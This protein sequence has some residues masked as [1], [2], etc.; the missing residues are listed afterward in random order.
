VDDRRLRL[1]VAVFWHN[2]CCRGCEPGVCGEC[3]DTIPVQWTGSVEF[4]AQCACD[5]CYSYSCY[6]SVLAET[7][8]GPIDFNLRGKP[9]EF[10][11]NC[12]WTDTK[13]FEFQPSYCE[14]C[15]PD[16]CEC[17]WNP[18]GHPSV[19]LCVRLT[20][21]CAGGFWTA[22]IGFSWSFNSPD[23]SGFP[24]WGWGFTVAG[25]CNECPPIDCNDEWSP[26]SFSNT[27]YVLGP[28]NTCDRWD[29]GNPIPPVIAFD[30]GTLVWGLGC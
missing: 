8:V 26:T 17:G 23:S 14:A 29:D 11:G 9:N 30:A 24:D 3:A 16:W 18:D 13:C 4:G 6:L 21:Q 5:G 19:H 15:C 22:N 27:P 28:G 1:E 7:T 20:L 25:S 10:S 2:L 12:V